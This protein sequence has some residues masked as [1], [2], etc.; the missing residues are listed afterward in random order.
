MKDLK[1]KL[2]NLDK[3]TK[4][5]LLEGGS[6][7]LDINFEKKTLMLSHAAFLCLGATIGLGESLAP[8]PALG[9]ASIT[10]ATS[11]VLGS[12][13]EAKKNE[14]KREIKEKYLINELNMSSKEDRSLYLDMDDDL[15]F[16]S[17]ES[18]SSPKLKV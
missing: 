18:K 4:G 13:K 8:M 12:V 14:A 15:F 3:N 10:L 7:I 2:N 1:E 5:L 17:I 6:N 9:L 11:F 16:K